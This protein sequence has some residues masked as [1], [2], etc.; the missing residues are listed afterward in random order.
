[1]ATEPPTLWLRLISDASQFSPHS[2]AQVRNVDRNPCG[3]A[4]I[5]ARRIIRRI[6]E[7]GMTPSD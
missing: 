2:C 5:P 7:S 4:A 3:D 1:M 6:V